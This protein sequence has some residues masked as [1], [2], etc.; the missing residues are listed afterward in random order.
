DLKK[1]QFQRLEFAQI[2]G[3]DTD[4]TLG[5]HDFST[6]QIASG[7]EFVILQVPNEIPY[8]G[9]GGGYNTK[10]VTVA[11]VSVAGGQVPALIVEGTA[12]VAVVAANSDTLEFFND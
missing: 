12:C 5:P 4:G 11:N 1:V 9:A 7:W 3:F 2:G 6:L 8:Y 10:K